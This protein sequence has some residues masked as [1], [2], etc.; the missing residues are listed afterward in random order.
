MVNSQGTVRFLR[1]GQKGPLRLDKVLLYVVK[2]QVLIQPLMELI[3]AQ[4]ASLW[5]RHCLVRERLKEWLKFIVH[6]LFNNSKA[7]CFASCTK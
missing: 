6:F 3:L 2:Q 7:C 5:H 1:P 4:M